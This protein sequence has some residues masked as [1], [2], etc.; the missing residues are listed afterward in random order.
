MLL[1]KTKFPEFVKPCPW[2]PFDVVKVNLT[3]LDNKLLDF[4]PTGVFKFK[5]IARNKGNETLF[6]ITVVFEL[7]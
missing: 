1:A 5:V 7:F 6:E 4:M 3:L 2:K